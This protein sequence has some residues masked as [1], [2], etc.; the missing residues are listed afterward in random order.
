VIGNAV[1]TIALHRLR[2]LLTVLGIV[3]GIASVVLAVASGEGAQREVLASIAH[4]NT[5][6]VTV[7][8][9][10]PVRSEVL[11]GTLTPADVERLAALPFV[12]GASP[13]ESKQTTLG[14]QGLTVQATLVG[15]APAFFSLMTI[16]VRSGHPFTAEALA[17]ADLEIVIDTRTQVALFASGEDPLGAVVLAGSVP[18]RVVG[19]VQPAVNSRYGWQPFA[20]LPY[21]T[22]RQRVANAG[23]FRRLTLQI[24]ETVDRGVGLAAIRKLL[25]AWHGRD[26]FQVL[27]TQ[28][29]RAAVLRTR[30][31]FSLLILAVAGIALMI[32]SIGVMNMMLVAVAERTR[33][34][35]LLMALGAR[36]RDVLLQFLIEAVVICGA[37]GVM[38]TALAFALGE[39]AR[40][41]DAP[42]TIL[43]GWETVAAA[44]LG[45]SLAGITA[46]MLP[47]RRAAQIDPAE[48][49]TR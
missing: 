36:R 7:E 25:A 21:T 15:V 6:V 49:L 16:P 26:D 27:D 22:Y 5:D 4:L 14:R 11:V 38:G 48:A 23:A 47:A 10:G 24:A 42:V 20:A 9:K 29:L 18:A 45:S 33:E 31:I 41:L 2:N 35:G 1:R 46:G 3:V 37:G 30:R 17:E 8:S 39:A 12:T 32:A 44:V 19:I 34:I 13:E 40:S 43:F 28:E